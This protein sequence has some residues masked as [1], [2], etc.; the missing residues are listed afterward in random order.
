MINRS[1]IAVR[2]RQPYIDWLLTLDI[3]DLRTPSTEDATLY[4]VP[5]CE[6]T[7]D[8]ARVMAQLHEQIFLHELTGRSPQEE[9][10]PQDR[11]LEVFKQW[12]DVEF[13]YG[14]CDAAGGPIQSEDY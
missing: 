6:D 2:P 9:T 7:D 11:S 1:A 5:W 10:W 3:C 13:F 12:F 4:L 14:V 8:V